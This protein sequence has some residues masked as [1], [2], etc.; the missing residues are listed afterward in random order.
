MN[1]EQART[2]L[3]NSATGKVPYADWVI[4]GRVIA[5]HYRRNPH[6]LTPM[7]LQNGKYVRDEAE[8]ARMRK[9]GQRIVWNDADPSGDDTMGDNPGGKVGARKV[10]SLSGDV[11]SY[12]VGVDDDG[13]AA[14]YQTVEA[15]DHA[16]PIVGSAGEPGRVE[17]FDRASAHN[18]LAA[19]NAANRKFWGG[20]KA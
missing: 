8:H 15:D 12:Y 5:D 9:P 13:N 7:R 18:S 17:L 1:L 10:M 2:L 11:S 6:M 4:A 14:L 3:N 16:E 20:G 19:I